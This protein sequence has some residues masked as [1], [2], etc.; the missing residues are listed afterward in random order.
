[1]KRSLTAL[2]AATLS[3]LVFAGPVAA[4]PPID[5]DPD[6]DPPGSNVEKPYDLTIRG[7]VQVNGCPAASPSNVAVTIHGT[8]VWN[9]EHSVTA[10]V[11]ATSTPGRFAYSAANLERGAYRVTGGLATGVCP[12][13]VWSPTAVS[14]PAALSIPNKVATADTM[15]YTAPANVTMLPGNLAALALQATFGNMQLHLNNFGPRHGLSNQLD[16]DSF[17]S[18]NGV[19]IPFTVPEFQ[20]DLDPCWVCPDF[21]QGR[22]YANDVNLESLSVAWSAGAFRLDGAFESTGRELKGIFT[23]DTLNVAT[24]DLMP[25]MQIDDAHLR[26]AIRPVADGNGSITYARFGTATLDGTIQATGACDV[27]VDVC[28]PLVGYKD[29]IRDKLNGP[30]QSVLDHP[31]PKAAVAAAMRQ[32]LDELGIGLVQG[33]FVEGDNIVVTWTARRWFPP[34]KDLPVI[35]VEPFVIGR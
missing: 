5:D 14:V 18:I 31:V 8:S 29:T 15:Q 19:T 11:S 24:D 35:S 34:V 26:F 22:F 12:Y 32:R 28:E 23:N 30:L 7:A 3:A 25:D 27:H 6:P 21:G 33:V 17:V 13:G 4:L 16:N 1:M 2:F 9:L 10:I 20:V